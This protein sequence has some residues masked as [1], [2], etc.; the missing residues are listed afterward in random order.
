[1]KLFSIIIPIFRVDEYLHECVDSVLNQSFKNIEIILI[2]DGSPDNSPQICDDYAQKDNRVKVIHKENGGLSDARN[3]GLRIAQ[4]EYVIFLDSDD[5]YNNMQFLA[6]L[7]V[8]ISQKSPDVI[9][10]QRQQFHDGNENK[11]KMPRQYSIELLNEQKNSRIVRLL[12]ETSQLEASSCMKAIRRELLLSNNLFFKEGIFSEDIEWFMRL[13]QTNP[14]VSVTNEVAYCYRLRSSS[15]S[16]SVG[17]KNI[18]DLYQI[19]D[20]YS[21]VYK[22]TDDLEFKK[23]MLNYL[24]YQLFIMMAYVHK[25]LRGRQRMEMVEQ[26]KKYLWLNRYAISK[27]TKLCKMLYL[28]GGYYFTSVVLS[29]YLILKKR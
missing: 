21:E 27:K 29:R 7:S 10:F 22:N 18:D 16:H 13:M 9:C 17:K 25:C 15:I 4:G 24:L 19:I 2:D 3:A 1:M 5:Y 6:S 20:E 8:I 26:C 12:S 28:I 14:S 11:M 23:G